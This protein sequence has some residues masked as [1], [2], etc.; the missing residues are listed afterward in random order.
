MQPPLKVKYLI[1]S[2]LRTKEYNYVFEISYSWTNVFIIYLLISLESSYIIL[3]Y[4]D[5]NSE[6]SVVVFDKLKIIKKLK[7]KEFVQKDN[8]QNEI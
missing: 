8:V 6:G 4:E 7:E 1:A 5:T 2:A 3:K